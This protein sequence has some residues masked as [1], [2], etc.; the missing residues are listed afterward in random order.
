[1]KKYGG[2]NKLRKKCIH[3]R[4]TKSLA[5]EESPRA[6]G[7]APVKKEKQKAE[8]EQAVYTSRSKRKIKKIKQLK[9]THSS[10]QTYSSSEDEEEV[11]PAQQPPPPP[12]ER[13]RPKLN[14]PPPA[15]K[16]DPPKKKKLEHVYK[17]GTGKKLA[18]APTNKAERPS[19]PDPPQ[20]SSPPSPR[21]PPPKVAPVVAPP[22]PVAPPKKKKKRVPKSLPFLVNTSISKGLV[23]E[24]IRVKTRAQEA[25]GTSREE[26]V[27]KL[28]EE[29]NF[30]RGV[31]LCG[32]L[33]VL[34]VYI[35]IAR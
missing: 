32:E 11:S 6:R 19:R 26:Q 25:I 10:S 15:K 4:C 5:K 18:P 33:H 1:M 9:P 22:A 30:F 28:D 3:R 23:E 8:E 24:E 31:Y 7:D 29:I 20:L 27:W 14:P 12:P 2:S 16:T 21:K 35:V 13:K 17:Y 34:L